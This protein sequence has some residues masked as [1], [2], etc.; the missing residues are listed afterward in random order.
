M[1]EITIHTGIIDS[2]VGINVDWFDENNIR[3]KERIAVIIEKQDKPRTL[4][5]TI[6]GNVVY[7]INSNEKKNDR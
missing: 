3:Y 7:R 6:N 2:H 5:I 4:L 1:S